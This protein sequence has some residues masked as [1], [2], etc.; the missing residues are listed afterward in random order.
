MFSAVIP[1]FNKEQTIVHSLQTVVNQTF[2]DFEIIIIDDG[3][4]DHSVELIR[5]N[6]QDS[7][8][9]IIQQ[10]NQ[11]VS[12]A[13]NHGVRESSFDYVAFLDADDEW[14]PTYLETMRGAVA[15]FP[16]ADMICTGGFYKDFRTGTVSSPNIIEEYL[17]ETLPLN[18]FINPGKMGHIGATII[19]K[20]LFLKVGGFPEE[21]SSCE[22][23]C[24]LMRVAL[25]GLF[26]YCGK[27]LHV[28]TSDVPGQTTRSDDWLLGRRTNA[29][30][31]ND[32]YGRYLM[33]SNRNLLIPV[34]M[35]YHLRHIIYNDLKAGRHIGV[36]TLMQHLST[37]CKKKLGLI[38]SKTVTKRWLKYFFI[39]YIGCTKMIWR[40]HGFP[41]IGEKIKNE[42]ALITRYHS[43]TID[44]SCKMKERY[45]L[46][47]NT[48]DNFED[49]WYPFFKLFSQY[50]KDCDG[51]IY[52]NTEYKD[53]SYEGLNIIPVKGCE[54]HDFPKTK[55]ATWSQCL[56][57]ALEEIDSEIILYMQEDYFLHNHVKNHIVNDFVQMMT[58]Q[59]EIECIQLTPNV[60]QGERSVYKHL[61]KIRMKKG[62]ISIVCCQASLW[63]K[64]T[65]L[66]FL[67]D[68]E[69]AWHFEAWGSK[70]A[71]F[72]KSNLFVVD[73]E[74]L[75]QESEITPYIFTGII[76]GKWNELAKK[77][78]SDHHIEMDFSKRGFV[79]DTGRPSIKERIIY[80]IL[81]SPVEL[82][83]YREW[84]MAK[85]RILMTCL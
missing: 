32:I 28:Y 72:L 54:K 12:A 57:W 46:L 29:F 79:Q 4:T 7:R 20:S 33:K 23:W 41:R 31:F 1:L 6:F 62:D 27:L 39:L 25:E 22:D 24:L 68:Y 84:L 55:R 15:Q 8:I 70:R 82:R 13:R 42:A 76:Q 36:E 63:K 64:T 19:R 69:T 59:P 78:F 21:I 77:L 74:M 73:E 48:C 16:E 50:W 56:R 26:V 85:L 49:C 47:I 51:K 58:Q 38:F 43:A 18:Y 53:F 52:L 5:Q 83:F 80:R 17:D 40:M 67:R 37:D 44:K 75:K 30:L 11:G 65:L 45:A 34:Y 61:N 35:K 3:S 10:K 2:R 66:K 81:N 14:L 60:A 9:R 71:R